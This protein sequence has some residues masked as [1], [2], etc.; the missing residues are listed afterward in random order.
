MDVLT[1]EQRK[2]CMSHIKGEDTKPEIIVRS[3][4]HNNGYRFRIHHSNL[5][6]KPDIVLKKY[7]LVIFVHGCYWHRHK[8]CKYATTPKTNYE[9][10]QAKFEENIARDTKNIEELSS[11]GWNVLILWECQVKTNEFISILDSKLK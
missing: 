1:K 3:W 9:F 4:L 5:P 2:K 10:W 8:N 11:Q 7:N 6:G